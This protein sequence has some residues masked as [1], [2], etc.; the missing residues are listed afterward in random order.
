MSEAQGI[1]VFCGLGVPSRKFSSTAFVCLFSHPSSSSTF[2][3]QLSIVINAAAIPH[4]LQKRGRKEE[5]G[6]RGVQMAW[7]KSRGTHAI[8]VPPSW[9]TGLVREGKGARSR[10]NLEVITSTA[11]NSIKS[12]RNSAAS[13][14]SLQRTR[15]SESRRVACWAA[16]LG[17]FFQITCNLGTRRQIIIA[18]GWGKGDRDRERDRKSERGGGGVDEGDADSK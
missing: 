1:C 11:G 9:H 7:G 12:D 8:A 4:S 18:G 6:A 2:L 13:L 15:G 10:H 3:L 14:T 17:C 5:S 16:W